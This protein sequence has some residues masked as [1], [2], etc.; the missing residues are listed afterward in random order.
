MADTMLL[1]DQWSSKLYT[2][3]HELRALLGKLFHV[4]QHCPPT[5]FFINRMLTTLTSCPLIGPVQL[6]QVFIIDT[7]WL[8]AYLPHT[9]GIYMIH[10]DDRRPAD[11]FVQD[12]W[13]Y[14]TLKLTMSGSRLECWVS[15]TP[16]VICQGF[17]L[18]ASEA[19]WFTCSVI[20]SPP[21]PFSR[22]GQAETNSFS[23]G[24]LA[25]STR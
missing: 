8:K 2:N 12:A 9:N 14:M 15:S 5:R 17:G 24:L 10:Q 16:S 21:W 18:H 23:P 1:V 7:Q 4:A 3:I 19:D 22:Q 25:L 13:H 11:L 20:T 6:M